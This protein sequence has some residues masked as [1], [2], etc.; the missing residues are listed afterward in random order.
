ML[1]ISSLR[2]QSNRQA[3]TDLVERTNKAVASIGK[4]KTRVEE[5]LSLLEDLKNALGDINANIPDKF[6]DALDISASKT[7]TIE[8][9]MV[10]LLTKSRTINT[11]IKDENQKQ[12]DEAI[13]NRDFFKRNLSELQIIREFNRRT[14]AGTWY[15]IDTI[16][17]FASSNLKGAEDTRKK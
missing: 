15:G 2:K 6:K 7:V 11:D 12:L 4:E 9:K 3:R 8:E 1:K 13:K 10:D 17:K 14:N 5:Q 16:S